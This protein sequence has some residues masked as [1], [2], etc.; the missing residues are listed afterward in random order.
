MVKLSMEATVEI[1]CQEIYCNI[2]NGVLE[3]KSKQ[4]EY[5]GAG[6]SRKVFRYGN[7]VFKIAKNGFGLLQNKA[8]VK[9]FN[10]I[11]GSLKDMICPILWYSDDYRIL[12]CKYAEPLYR[13][14]GWHK[15]PFT[16]IESNE[17]CEKV[18]YN[19]E[20]DY[21]LTCL[22]MHYGLD[23]HDLYKVSSWGVLDNKPVLVDYG[24]DDHVASYSFGIE[25][26]TRLINF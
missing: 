2:L 26:S 13:A 16:R 20:L 23:K 3:Y 14:D 1:D 4:L 12:I 5:V 11:E 24:Y 17:Y 10:N 18:H 9:L 22:Y 15:D 21:K 6:A 8:E 7:V 25:Y 19:Q